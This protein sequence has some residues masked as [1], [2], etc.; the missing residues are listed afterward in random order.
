[1]EDESHLYSEVKH[2]DTQ[3]TSIVVTAGMEDEKDHCSVVKHPDT[4]DKQ[5]SSTMAACSNEIPDKSMCY[6]FVLIIIQGLHKEIAVGLHS[7][8]WLHHIRTSSGWVGG[9]GGGGGGEGGKEGGTFMGKGLLSP[10][11]T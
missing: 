5:I 7:S 4:Q 11:P 9:G 10:L 8:S 3:D 1:M 6:R 2:P